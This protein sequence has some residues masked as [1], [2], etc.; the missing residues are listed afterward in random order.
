MY[1]VANVPELF[2]KYCKGDDTFCLTPEFAPAISKT[3]KTERSMI[4]PR[5]IGVLPGIYRFI[6]E[7]PGKSAVQG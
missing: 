4:A 3:R 6:S 5:C 2:C 7:Y 1:I